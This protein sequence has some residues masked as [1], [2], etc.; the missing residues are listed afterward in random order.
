VNLFLKKQVK[1]TLLEQPF[2]QLRMMFD[3]K[4]S[5]QNEELS[6]NLHSCIGLD[7]MQL[8]SKGDRFLVD[9]FAPFVKK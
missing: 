7:L 8:Q 1:N 4:Q 6:W 5:P 2:S 9:I 3:L